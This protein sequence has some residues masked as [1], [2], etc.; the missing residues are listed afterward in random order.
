MPT[1]T[2]A[3][4]LAEIEFLVSSRHRVSVLDA[5]SER[6]RSRSDLRE[7]TGAS[8]STIS[9]T[10]AGFE[11]RCWIERTGHRY[12][13]TPLGS[14]VAEGTA[15]L[16]GRMETE[17]KL[18]EVLRW[19]PSADVQFDVVERP[20]DAVVVFATESDPMA[21]L[22]RAAEQLRD[23]ARLRFLTTQVAAWYFHRVDEHV[24]RNDRVVEGVVT[25]C[26]LETLTNDP[27][28][29]A[30]SREIRDSGNATLFVSDAVPMKLHVVG[31]AVGIALVDD[32]TTLR[33][34]V[35]STDDA[36]HEWAVGVA[37]VDAVVLLGRAGRA[38]RTLHRGW[39]RLFVAC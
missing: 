1:Y 4:P 22:R 39:R 35:S 5:L 8:A 23:G 26:V 38:L 34:L 3:T 27:A 15:A 28:L 6:P 2:T 21:P 13:A 36:V 17:G 9:R 24:A 11:D 19:F 18:R 33:G 12:E 30:V 20:A 29:S 37:A 14:F 25:P 10:L 31:D 16:L 32:S 7:R